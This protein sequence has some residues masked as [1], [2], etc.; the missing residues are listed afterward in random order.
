MY[1]SPDDR[2]DAT[3][4]VNS[5]I[6]PIVIMIILVRLIILFGQRLIISAGAARSDNP[7]LIGR[8][9]L[10]METKREPITIRSL[11]V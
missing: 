11:F 10:Q 8:K 5:F 3:D 9:S 4:G 6:G 1:W 7:M 2:T